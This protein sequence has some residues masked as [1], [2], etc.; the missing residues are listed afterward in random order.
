MV[1]LGCQGGYNWNLLKKKQSQEKQ[2]GTPV[3]G[4]G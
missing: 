3:R 4:F 2:L 1:I